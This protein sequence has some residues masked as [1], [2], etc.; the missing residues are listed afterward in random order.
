MITAVMI[1][2]REP[3]WLQEL[4][5]SGVPTA[6]IALDAGDLQV[7]CEDGCTLLIERKTPDDLLNTLRDD[8]LMPQIA[9]LV[10]ARLDDQAASTKINTWPYLI[11][12]GQLYRGA[13]GKTVTGDRGQTGWD[14]NAVQGAL[15]TVQEMGCMVIFAGGD[16]DF[17]DCVIRLSKRSRG[18]IKIVPPRPPNILGAGAAFLAG[19]PGVGPEHAMQLMQWA[20]NIPAHAIAG[21]ID[22]EITCP[23]P[24]ST[25]K[26]VR[27][28]L[29]LTDQQNLDLSMNEKNQVV[30]DVI[31][32]V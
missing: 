5:F 2:S 14:W 15:L 3:S 32:K 4:K 25:R 16:S 7:L 30:L 28:M 13:N 24:M 9:R 19:L 26:K 17:E 8:R 11:I 20:G 22:L 29:G 23:L 31:E 12:T 1:D 21:I 6:V 10:Q 18:E 27:A